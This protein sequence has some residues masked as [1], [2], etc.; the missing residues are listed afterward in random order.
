MAMM[1]T[2]SSS[3]LRESYITEQQTVVETCCNAVDPCLVSSLYQVGLSV[4]T[5]GSLRAVTTSP[6]VLKVGQL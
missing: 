1:R 4:H 5:Y 3:A 6:A 2:I